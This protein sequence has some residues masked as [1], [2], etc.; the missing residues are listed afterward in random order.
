[1]LLNY[2]TFDDGR[3]MR[4]YFMSHVYRSHTSCSCLRS[5]CTFFPFVQQKNGGNFTFVENGKSNS[6][7]W[8]YF[9]ALDFMIR[10][11]KEK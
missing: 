1:M 10:N 11:L 7:G 6:C 8:N 4:A 2:E 5:F 9:L 3:E